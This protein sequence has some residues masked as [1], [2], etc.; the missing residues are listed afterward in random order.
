MKTRLNKTT[1]E[2][3][4]PGKKDVY[5]W[6]DRAAGFGVKVTPRGTRVYVLKYR[7]GRAQRWVVIGRH[8]DIT[9]DEARQRAIKLRGAIAGGADPARMRDEHAAEPTV[10]ELADRYLEEYAE[11][12]KKPRS[13]E[14]DRR[15][16]AKH[17][18]PA[19]GSLKAGAVTRQDAL[20]LRHKM[21]ATPGAA[22][23]VQ[24]L[25]S[26]MF[27]L[28]EEWGIR[29]EG[30][31]PC[32]RI[33]KFPE[34]QRERFLSTDELRR[35]GT[36]F[37]DAAKEGERL[38]GIAIIRLLLLTGCRLSEITTLKWAF[39]D[40]ERSCLRLPDS[41]TGAKVVHL[42]APALD[43][44]AGLP[45]GTGPYVFPGRRPNEL[46]SRIGVHRAWIR[47]RSRAGLADVRLHDLRHTFASWSVMGGAS[48]PM[49]GALLGHRQAATTQRY[50]HFASDPVQEAAERVTAT[51]DAALA[52]TVRAEVVD[53][54]S[55]RRSK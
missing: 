25:L 10:D 9:A 24:A 35:L 20:K 52:G 27:S 19:L 8:G 6:D 37:A 13:I 39:V 33:A 49:I 34:K 48:L 7:V 41:K 32:R 47:I 53:L 29:S 4:E 21:R 45:R 43:L 5:G 15:N 11:S 2:A 14:E 22:N 46:P 23:R 26:K 12:H 30:S 17:I 28:A 1:V 55:S 36:A 40:F 54:G 42:G 38:S 50:A 44:L 51:L 16:L 3:I 18:R 31:N